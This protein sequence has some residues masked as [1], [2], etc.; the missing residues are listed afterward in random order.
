M[1]S[2]D[3]PGWNSRFTDRST[4]AFAV[5]LGAFGWALACSTAM[6]LTWFVTS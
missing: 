1:E 6:I 5:A 3:K 4:I 2:R